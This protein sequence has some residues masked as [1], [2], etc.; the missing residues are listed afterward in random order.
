MSWWAQ[1]KRRLTE[2]WVC[3]FGVMPSAEG[4][5]PEYLRNNP[6]AQRRVEVRLHELR[7]EFLAKNQRIE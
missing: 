4:R 7:D 1:A 5:R 3:D 6:E 2:E